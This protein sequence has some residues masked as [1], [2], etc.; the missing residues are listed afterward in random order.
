[1]V[2]RFYSDTPPSDNSGDN[3]APLSTFGLLV[4]SLS[5]RWGRLLHGWIC[6]QRHGCSKVCPSYCSKSAVS[7]QRRRIVEDEALEEVKSS[8]ACVFTSATFGAEKLTDFR[9]DSCHGGPEEL[10]HDFPNSV[11]QLLRSGDFSQRLILVSK[12]APN[13]ITA[14]LTSVAVK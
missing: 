10:N 14:S 2:E 1:M 13:S 9:P 5:S 7:G 12:G 11:M 6:C 3:A 8:W 4:E